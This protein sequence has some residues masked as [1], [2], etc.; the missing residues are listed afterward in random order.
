MTSQKINNNF[1]VSSSRSDNL[2][3]HTWYKCFLRRHP[4]VS[5]RTPEGVS[6]A[7]S[8][9]SERDIR[10]WFKNIAEYFE[11]KDLS[12]VLGDPTRI[13]NADETSFQLC[14]KTGKVLAPKGLCLL[15]AH[16]QNYFVVYN[17]NKIFLI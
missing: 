5:L 11:G 4:K 6:D 2:P 3:G 9:V 7:S 15:Y 12:D 16:V 14:P 10:D 17:P 13:Y 8:K 1:L